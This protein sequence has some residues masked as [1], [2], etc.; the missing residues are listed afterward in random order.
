[1]LRRFLPI[2]AVGVLAVGACSSPPSDRARAVP[3]VGV[4]F[5][6]PRALLDDVD[7]MSLYVIDEAQTKATCVPGTG[8]VQSLAG[9]TGLVPSDMAS[10]DAIVF[11]LARRMADG[12]ACPDNGVFC[13]DEISLPTA[14]DLRLV[15]QAVAHKQ[16]IARAVG[17]AAGAVNSDPF[18]VSIRMHRYVAPAVC[19][20]GL[21][22]VGEQCEG[23]GGPPLPNDPFCDQSCRSNELLLSTDH[24]GPSNIRVTN[25]PPGSKNRVDLA[26]SVAPNAN[27]P[28][29]LHAVFQDTNFGPTGSGPEI[30]YRQMNQALQPVETPALLSSQIRLPLAGGHIP[31]FDQRPRTQGAPAIATMTDGSIVVAYEDDRTSAGGQV[32]ISFTASSLDIAVPRADEIYINKQGVNTC[33]EPDVA[34]GPTDR[35]LVVWS[36]TAARRVRGRRWESTGWLSPSDKTFSADAADQPAVSGWNEGWILTWHGRSAADNDDILLV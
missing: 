10:I 12:S 30:N 36:D 34:G 23:D 2:T 4:A 6:A 8:M 1:M 25:D 17:C 3:H 24:L 19:G 15:F 31:G 27:T 26:W 29:P 28:N 35:A 22:Q 18:Y 7:S 20:D 16:G 33:S 21:L 9:T 5:H 13:S 32:N 11:P 14:P